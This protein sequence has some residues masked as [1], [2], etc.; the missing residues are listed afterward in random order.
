MITTPHTAPRPIHSALAILIVPG[1]AFVDTALAFLGGW[2]PEGQIEH[3]LLAA[4]SLWISFGIVFLAPTARRRL[5]GLWRELLLLTIVASVGWSVLEATAHYLEGMLQPTA[6]FHTRGADM[7]VIH[8]P[9][10]E[11]IRGITGPSAFTTGSDGVRPATP[12]AS[13]PTIR[14]LCIGGST[15]ECVYLDDAE[16]WPALVGQQLGRD[17]WVGN[18][19]ISGFYT[20]DHL[21]FLQHAPLLRSS[22]ALIVQP[23]INDLWRFLAGEE[24]HTDFGRFESTEENPHPHDM[25]PA[26]YRPLWTRSRLIQLFHTL[27]ADPPPVEVREGIGGQEYQIRREKRAHAVLTDQLPD[28]SEGLAG[29]RNRLLEIINIC[30]KSDV[31]VLFTTQPVLWRDDLSHEDASLCWFGWLPDGRY[32]SLGA[33]RAAMD[34]YNEV[35]RETCR[36]AGVPFVDLSPMNGDPRWFYDDCHFTEAGAVEVARR[37]APELSTLIGEARP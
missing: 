17:V 13:N 16:T 10:P 31:P 6:P 8:H 33:L 15:T 22:N 5:G 14:V 19:G 37:I 12:S 32:L 34:R 11:H 24:D 27:R 25:R 4:F 29:Y 9:D 18:V 28:L 21:H 7:R 3:L 23:G 30:V 35:L 20:Q 2:R 26:P 1:L 36:E